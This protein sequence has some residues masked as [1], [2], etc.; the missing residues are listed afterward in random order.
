[1]SEVRCVASPHAQVGEGPVWD[2]R[3]GVLWWVDI[4]Q[5]RLFRYDP[6]RL[7]A[8]PGVS[9]WVDRRRPYDRRSGQR[10]F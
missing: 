7:R 3:E 8:R 5:P 2:D 9:G 1:M 6:L 4:K 10:M